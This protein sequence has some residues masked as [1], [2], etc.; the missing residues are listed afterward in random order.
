MF[1]MSEHGLA[2]GISSERITIKF[3]VDDPIDLLELAAAFAGISKQYLKHL[4]RTST[5]ESLDE[6]EV[7][8]YVTSIKSNCITTEL[9]P[10][11][12]A[13]FQTVQM[14]DWHNNLYDFVKIMHTYIQYFAGKA[15]SVFGNQAKISDCREFK[16]IL[17]TVAG[18]RTGELTLEVKGPQGSSLR[19]HYQSTETAAALAGVQKKIAE[20]E[21]KEAAEHQAVLMY[22]PQLNTD[23]HKSGGRTADRGVIESICSRPL[24][25]YWLS[26]LDSQKVKSQETNPHKV[27]YIVDVNVETKQQVPK[28][29]RVVRLIEIL[30]ST[31][32]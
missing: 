25:V 28:A 13:A 19:Y 30:P 17:E 20:L 6:A 3:D 8:L 26:E 21:L 11:A 14:I 27:S 5:L 7:K 16:D 1:L 29:Y 2:R 4:K 10:W 18:K 22:L 31:E 24:P 32:D 23:E 12:A 15:N 9:G